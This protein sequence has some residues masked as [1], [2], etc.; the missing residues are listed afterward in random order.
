M[1][2]AHELNI[3]N[4]LSKKLSKVTTEYQK[5]SIIHISVITLCNKM[6]YNIKIQRIIESIM[7]L[8]RGKGNPNPKKTGS[9]GRV[10]SSKRE[11]DYQVILAPL[12]LSYSNTLGLT[13]VYVV[14]RLVAVFE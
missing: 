8:D 5:L 7:G 6:Q 3:P 2:M 12:K 10:D 9:T 11:S 14:K 13:I 1:M 4:V